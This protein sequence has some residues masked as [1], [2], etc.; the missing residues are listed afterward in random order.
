M[1]NL[2]YIVYDKDLGKD[3]GKTCLTKYK[4]K[5]KIGINRKIPF[6]VTIPIAKVSNPKAIQDDRLLKV[7]IRKITDKTY[8]DLLNDLAKEF[9]KLHYQEVL[10]TVPASALQDIWDVIQKSAEK[11]G[12]EIGKE[13]LPVL[14]KYLDA[15]KEGKAASFKFKYNRFKCGLAVAGSVGATTAAALSLAAAS[16]ATMGTAS[17][18]LVLVAAGG[19]TRDHVKRS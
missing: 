14:R 5:V 12:D 6:E 13:A 11:A 1:P 8:G 2:E 7:K 15:R 17:A 16:A 4:G 18:G 9:G 19:G 3:I 10:G